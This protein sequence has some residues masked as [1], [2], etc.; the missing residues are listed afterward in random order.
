MVPLRHLAG[1]HMDNTRSVFSNASTMRY[2]QRFYKH[3]SHLLYNCGIVNNSFQIK[4][5]YISNNR[6]SILTDTA[7]EALLVATERTT[8]LKNTLVKD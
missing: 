4:L 6:Y 7:Y 3:K 8:S 1:P 5:G 2:S